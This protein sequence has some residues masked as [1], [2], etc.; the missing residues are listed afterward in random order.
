MMAICFKFYQSTS[1]PPI[2]HS[3]VS[4][5]SSLMALSPPKN[6]SS[7]KGKRYKSTSF[8]RAPL[9]T[10][11][12]EVP[13]VSPPRFTQ[14]SASSS[15]SGSKIFIET[16]ILDS[17]SDSSDGDDSVVL[18]KLLSRFKIGDWFGESSTPAPT[19][20]GISSPTRAASPLN[21]THHTTDSED[22]FKTDEVESSEDIDD[23]YIPAPK[24]TH[25]PEETHVPNITFTLSPANKTLEPPL[26]EVL[27]DLT[28]S[29][30]P[31]GYVGSSSQRPKK[32]LSKGRLIRTIFEVGPLY[33]RLIQELVVNLPSDFNDLSADEFHKVH[34]KGV[35]FTISSKFFNQFL[36][37]TLPVDY[38]VSFPTLEH[39]VEELTDGTMP[40][41]PVGG[42]LPVASLTIKYVILHK[43][44]TFVIHISICFPRLLSSFLLS[45]HPTILTLIHV[46]GIAP[47]GSSAASSIV[48]QSL[49]VLVALVALESTASSSDPQA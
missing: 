24:E 15:I 35:C 33:P 36:G 30:L 23:D 6:A 48:D 31:P 12:I 11:K 47:R 32:P 17:N 39:L 7:T 21:V 26:I 46:V 41:W 5:E 43:I 8:S 13:N 22:S 10:I 29:I 4:V 1:S 9:V 16:V 18:W 40:I 14:P 19:A 37:I 28:T 20:Q 44:D 45:Q 27:R 42:Q 49:V 2:R 34:I 38:L 3:F 25:V